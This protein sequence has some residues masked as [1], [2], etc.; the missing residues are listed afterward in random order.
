MINEVIHQIIDLDQRA[1][2][3][4]ESA[5]ARAEKIVTDTKE[6]LK[7]EETKIIT[8]AKEESKSNYDVEIKKAEEEK[9]NAI[10]ETSSVLETVREKY[11]NAK[12][13]TARKVLDE[14]FQSI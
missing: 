7:Q 1:V 10:N 4:K 8:A 12:K 6:E 14:L 2:R 9:A 5:T 13:D 3:I 11:E